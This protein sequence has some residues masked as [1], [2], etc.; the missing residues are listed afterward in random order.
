MRC[1]AGFGGIILW[2][3]LA[4]AG[5]RQKDSLGVRAGEI[6]YVSSIGDQRTGDSRQRRQVDHCFTKKGNTPSHTHSHTWGKHLKNRH[7]KNFKLNFFRPAPPSPIL[8]CPP[9]PF[10]ICVLFFVRKSLLC[11]T[12]VPFDVLVVSGTYLLPSISSLS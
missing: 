2:I 4:G 11:G 1:P 5:P 7:C 6:N 12:W 9:A 10:S 3:I 8:T